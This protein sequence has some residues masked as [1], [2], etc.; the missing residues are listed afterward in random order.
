M[1]SEGG[2]IHVKHRLHR[3][4]RLTRIKAWAGAAS[5]NGRIENDSEEETSP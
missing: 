1:L 4:E 5:N 2:L 3:R